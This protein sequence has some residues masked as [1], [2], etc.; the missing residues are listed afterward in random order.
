MRVGSGMNSLQGIMTQEDLETIPPSVANV[1]PAEDAGATSSSYYEFQYGWVAR[2]ALEMT[3]EG[4]GLKWILCEWHT[5]FVLGWADSFAPVSVKHRE[6][7]SGHWTIATMFSEGGL[8]TL[9]AR[10]R[11]LGRPTM[12]RWVTNGGL[13][14]ECKRLQAAC[15]AT[16]VAQFKKWFAKHGFRFEK[17]KCAD[18][19]AFL[20][21]LRIDNDSSRSKD[22][23]IV[24]IDR[25]ARPMLRNL[26]LSA[27]EAPAVYDAVVGIA[28][29]ASQ[30]FGGTEPATWSSSRRDAFDAVVLATADSDKRV[31]RAEPI[32]NVAR[33]LCEPAA[34]VPPPTSP[35][36]TTLTKKLQRG[37]VV[38]TAEMA[39]RRTRMGWAA[40][41]AAFSEPLPVPG[42]QSSL[43]ELRSRVL[44]EAADAHIGAAKRSQPY[45]NVMYEE[46][47]TRMKALAADPSSLTWLTPDLLMGLVYDLTAHCEIWWSERFDLDA[48]DVGDGDGEGDEG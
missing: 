35:E 46:M 28:R 33:H 36:N 21:A 47:R 3:D 41:E 10:W 16:D 30:G 11:E 18:V 12:C 45:G 6:P 27:V 44:M 48:A 37:E 24:Q 7:N 43:E 32:Q 9:Y 20:T 13:N 17:A 4:S 29:T 23:R 40:Y 42:Q 39:A 1:R 14:G 31:I 5:D 34:A 25:I 15:A 8:N 38:P 19:V 2:H 26:G 22:Q